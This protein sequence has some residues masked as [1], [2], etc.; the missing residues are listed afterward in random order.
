MRGSSSHYGG[1]LNDL[2]THEVIT[3]EYLMARHFARTGQ[4]SK[5]RDWG[6]DVLA[7]LFPAAR[8]SLATDRPKW[9]T[10]VECYYLWPSEGS[11]N[12]TVLAILYQQRSILGV[13]CVAIRQ[14][15][16]RIK[17]GER[18]TVNFQWHGYQK[19]CLRPTVDL[20]HRYMYG[21]T[22]DGP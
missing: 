8:W 9:T 12:A 11:T 14:F 20:T 1:T 10:V 13:L 4:P 17:S 5:D 2:Y 7:E 16:P 3:V 18:K 21:M 22:L 6:N 15:D 19:P